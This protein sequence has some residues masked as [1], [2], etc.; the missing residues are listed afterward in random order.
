MSF[1]LQHS[2]GTSPTGKGRLHEVFPGSHLSNML[3]SVLPCAKPWSGASANGVRGMALSGIFPQTHAPG[4]L[5]LPDFTDMSGLGL[6]IAD[7]PLNHR[8]YEN[9]FSGRNKIMSE[10]L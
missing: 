9:G 4:R 3:T 7:A 1:A 10:Y 5:G 2:F 6:L 8:L